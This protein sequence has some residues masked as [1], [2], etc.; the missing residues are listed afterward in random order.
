MT[1]KPCLLL[2][3]NVF[4]ITSFG[5]I[6]QKVSY[7]KEHDKCIGETWV[8]LVHVVVLCSGQYMS[9]ERQQARE[10]QP[11]DELFEQV[12]KQGEHHEL[13]QNTT[14]IPQKIPFVYCSMQCCL[15]NF[16]SVW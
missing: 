8:L 15:G 13:P 4:C 16:V 12:G 5:D 1:D 9:A 3:I 2:I 7:F 14:E 10:Y 6:P 11:V